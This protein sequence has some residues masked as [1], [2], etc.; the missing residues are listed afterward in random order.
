MTQS[1]ISEVRQG[2]RAAITAL[3]LGQSFSPNPIDIVSVSP[4]NEIIQNKFRTE[5]INLMSVNTSNELVQENKRKK[6]GLLNIR[7][8]G[9]KGV[10]VNVLM[11]EYQ[12]DLFWLAGP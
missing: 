3:P 12:V 10:L 5:N 2:G 7:S 9:F 4:S 1:T 11:S 6:C 8:L